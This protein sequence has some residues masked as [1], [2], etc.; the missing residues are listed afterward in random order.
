MQYALF[1]FSGY[2]LV[3]TSL[4]VEMP[5]GLMETVIERVMYVKDCWWLGTPLGVFKVTSSQLEHFMFR[6]APMLSKEGVV[7]S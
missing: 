5:T 6:S 3:G 4:T 1:R 2:D 7:L